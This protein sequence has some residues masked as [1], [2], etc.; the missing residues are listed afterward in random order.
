M[1][2]CHPEPNVAHSKQGE[3][4][5][6]ARCTG[7]S[8]TAPRACCVACHTAPAHKPSWPTD[9]PHPSRMPQPPKRP[10]GARRCK[11]TPEHISKDIIP[12]RRHSAHLCHLLHR[13]PACRGHKASRSERGI[14]TP[15][16]EALAANR[17][18]RQA[19]RTEQTTAQAKCVKPAPLPNIISTFSSPSGAIKCPARPTQCTSNIQQR[20]TPCDIRV[21][22]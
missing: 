22:V 7:W 8:S 5:D 13:E 10:P 20:S 15:H 11:Q 3:E 19:L 12:Y 2:Q 1:L 9:P 18:G 6:E 16:R 17:N 4:H 21:L 14:G